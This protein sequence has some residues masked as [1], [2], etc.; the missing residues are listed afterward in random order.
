MLLA[1]FGTRQFMAKAAAVAT[2]GGGKRVKQESEA[3]P[4]EV[5]NSKPHLST[6]DKQ[7]VT[8]IWNFMIANP[9]LIL[10]TKAHLE[11]GLITNKKT[12]DEDLYFHRTY[13]IFKHIKKGS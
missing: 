8:W 9:A 5:Q 7:A 11:A 1:G 13:T 4:Q 2:H 6:I 10:I 12:D 3:A